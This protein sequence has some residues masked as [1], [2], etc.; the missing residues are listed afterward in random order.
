VPVLENNPN[1]PERG[2]FDLVM[3]GGK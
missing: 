1:F 2:T 3:E